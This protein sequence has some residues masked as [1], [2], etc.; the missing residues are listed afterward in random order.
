MDNAKIRKVVL[1]AGARPNFMKIAPLIDAIKKAQGLGK[2]IEYTL[3]HTGQHYDSKMSDDFFVQLGIPQPNINLEAG[4]GSQSEQTAA[5]M[6]RFE[7]YLIENPTDLVLVVGDVT[8]TLACSIVAKKLNTRVAHVEGGIRSGDMTM[9]E[10]INRL[11][12]DSISDYF[13]TTSEIANEN[14]IR[15]GK[16]KEQ[17]Y[18]VGNTMIDTLL[19]NADRFRKPDCWDNLSL[20]PQKYIVITLHRPSNVD[21]KEQIES[22]FAAIESSIGDLPIIFPVHP[23]T[24]KNIE[25]FG[26]TTSKIKL[27]DPMGYLEFNFLVKN[28]LGVI[29]D[30]GGV[31]EETTVMGVPCITLR[32]STERPETCTI[33]TNELIGTMPNAIIPAI[34]KL[35]S[36]NW[37]KG[38]IPELWD[39]R[40]SERIVNILLEM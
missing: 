40:T 5:I 14:L 27:I 3:V 20:I 1:I 21:R 33:G 12:T 31:T 30:S 32:D 13:F 26:I 34:L 2:K 10:E 7:K 36:G 8:S 23:R 29:T 15:E 38:G 22:I 28:A 35:K 17:I 19:K 4:G 18:F 16:R 39:G 6:I 24:R 9:P 37:K 25:S 11:V